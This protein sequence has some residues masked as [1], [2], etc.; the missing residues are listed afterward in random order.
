MSGDQEPFLEHKEDENGLSEGPSRINKYDGRKRSR[1]T[2]LLVQ[3]VL[4]AIYT[5]FSIVYV[6]RTS[7]CQTIYSN[8]QLLLLN[9]IN[10]NSL[11]CITSTAERPSHQ[12]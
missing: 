9:P 5:T 11:T 2:F 12:L 3:L 6:Q 7:P 4:V 8:G 1:K 10:Q